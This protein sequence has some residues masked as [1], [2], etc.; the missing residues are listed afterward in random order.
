ML[1][2]KTQRQYAAEQ[3]A[4]DSEYSAELAQARLEVEFAVALAKLREKRGLSQREVAAAAGIGQPML[5]RYEKGDQL[6]TLP[7]LQ[8]LAHALNARVTL[9][10]NAIAIAP[11]PGR[12]LA[13]P[14]ARRRS[15]RSPRQLART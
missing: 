8:R 9:S 1:N 4:K 13:A 12:R 15:A 3:C 5:A 14:A 10:P 2:F 7:T 11:E 6:P